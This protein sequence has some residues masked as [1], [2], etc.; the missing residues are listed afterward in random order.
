MSNDMQENKATQIP[1]QEISSENEGCATPSP[2]TRLTREEGRAMIAEH[3]AAAER[4]M[5]R[6]E[7]L[8]ML[9]KKC[10]ARRVTDD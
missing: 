4:V 2:R 10:P 5:R 1:S 3:E 8:N 7:E 9:P 6:L